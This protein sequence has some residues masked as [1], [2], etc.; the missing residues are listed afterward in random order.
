MGH[1]N[2]DLADP[3]FCL[4]RIIYLEHRFTPP[5]PAKR[6]RHQTQAVLAP[7]QVSPHLASPRFVCNSRKQ[8]ANPTLLHAISPMPSCP[9]RTLAYIVLNRSQP[10]QIEAVSPATGDIFEIDDAERDALRGKP[11]SA[12][13]PSLTTL[14]P[15]D[16]CTRYR[17]YSVPRRPRTS[18][19]GARDS[20]ETPL[21]VDPAVADTR[22]T[23]ATGV[24]HRLLIHGCLHT[25]LNAQ[26]G[27]LMLL[28]NVTALN[29]LVPCADLPQRADGWLLTWLP[30]AAKTCRDA[31]Q[32]AA[33]TPPAYWL[34]G[35][36][37]ETPTDR[38][39]PS[40]PDH[41]PEQAARVVARIDPA[42]GQ[43]AVCLT[44]F[45][46]VDYAYPNAFLGTTA[47]AMTGQSLMHWIASEDVGR[48][49]Q[50]MH[51]A[52]QTSF[53]RFPVRWR[54]GRDADL[55]RPRG[56]LPDASVDATD[57]RAGGIEHQDGDEAA[58]LK[59]F[60]WVEFCVTLDDGMPI[61]V[62]RALTDPI[63]V[64]VD[65]ATTS[66]ST[67]LDKHRA[68][69][70]HGPESALATAG[71][72][73]QQ[74]SGLI[75]FPG[76]VSTDPGPG[77]LIAWPPPIARW[78]DH[79]LRGIHGLLLPFMH[80]VHTVASLASTLMSLSI[81]VYPTQPL[82]ASMNLVDG[83]DR[84]SGAPRRPA[85]SSNPAPLSPSSQKVTRPRGIYLQQYVH[86]VRRNVLGWM[87]WGSGD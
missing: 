37:A 31:G 70:V 32:A 15:C 22:N 18:D 49:C 69:A 9:L 85:S 47:A 72:D 42:P 46:I 73:L 13:L 61:C 74:R 56:S 81:P 55:R 17:I 80:P 82:P 52:C 78:L 2:S 84:T 41:A 71:P 21:H 50:G 53:A 76:D 30:R 40:V 26:Q 67:T 3:P 8:R 35:A 57:C 5:I 33:L 45:G 27:P 12:L 64:Q 66:P 25:S 20:T 86:H 75:R 60:T 83:T 68:E 65:A 34:L 44:R 38:P 23:T 63:A 48:L 7:R 10:W 19:P 77:S 79:P 58:A 87:G 62:L 16:D 11:L 6:R 28:R 36:A 24:E 51:R 43:I 54:S 4:D 59:G 29:V 1:A 14:P 39:H